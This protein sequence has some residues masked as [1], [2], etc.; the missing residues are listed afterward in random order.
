MT[1]DAA[2]HGAALEAAR[3]LATA[4]RNAYR[5]RAES[6]HRLP[7]VTLREAHRLKGALNF[8]AERASALSAEAAKAGRRRRAGRPRKEETGK[9]PLVIGALEEH[10]R[11]QERGSVENWDAAT[12]GK[13]ASLASGDR[14][15]VSASTVSRFFKD[16]FRNRGYKGYVSACNQRTIQ[17]I[18]LLLMLWR[19]ELPTHLPDL[20][21]HES[22]AGDED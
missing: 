8:E 17:H 14:V 11:Y 4:W 10:H 21:P 16:K 20:L 12:L 6:P 7:E 15:K 3:R 19:G 9:Y 18:G 5:E 22:G 1:Q 2:A 13:L